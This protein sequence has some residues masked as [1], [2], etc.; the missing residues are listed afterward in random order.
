MS[1]WTISYAVLLYVAFVVFVGGLIYRIALYSLT[2]APLRIPTMPAPRTRSGVVLRMGREVGLFSSLFRG[3]KW[4]WIWSYLFHVSLLLVL[5]QHLRYVLNPI[6]LWV[7]W[8]SPFGSYAAFV[9]LIS[10]AGLLGRRLSVARVR[11][12]SAPSDYLMLILLLVIA[13]TGALMRFLDRANIVAFKAFLF[14]VMAGHWRPLPV[15]GLILVHVASVAFLMLIFPF[16]K[17]LHAPGVFFSPTRN[18]VDNSRI[19]GVGG[20]AVDGGERTP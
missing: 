13:V 16:S 15:E 2:P 19:E 10:L 6:P 4:A 20:D 3:D 8:E 5:V 11:F 18:Q 9:L 1:T 17:L 12:I 7:R 14:G